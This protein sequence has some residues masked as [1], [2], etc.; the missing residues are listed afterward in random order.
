MEGGTSAGAGRVG[1]GL[2]STKEPAISRVKF[3][4]R[5]ALAFS[6]GFVANLGAAPDAVFINGNIYT[7]NTK[8]PHAESIAVQDGR[9][10]F[11]G[12]SAAAKKLADTAR[13]ISRMC[14]AVMIRNDSQSD[15]EEFAQH[16]RVPVINGLSDKHHPCQLLADLQTWFEHRGDPKGK[17]AAWI[18]DG[19]NVCHSWMEAA[20]LIGFRLRIAT[21]KSYEPNAALTAEAGDAVELMREPVFA[22]KG[23]DLIITDTWTSMGQEKESRTRLAAFSGYQVNAALMARAKPD[24]LF[25]HCLPAHRGEEVSADV[26]D[27]AQS[28][29]WDEAEN[30]LHAQKALLEFLLK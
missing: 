13:V 23:A 26:I 12:S 19:N 28:V 24:A 2:D 6:F 25:M 10:T 29:V 5:I 17:T 30:R 15:Q 1:P 20:R 18:G 3:S 22:A 4:F 14:D 7:G 9:I 8:Q 27:G 11:V 21:P 16:S